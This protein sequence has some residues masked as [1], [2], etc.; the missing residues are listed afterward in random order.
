M[1]VPRNTKCNPYAAHFPYNLSNPGN[2][3]TS[4]KQYSTKSRLTLLCPSINSA[5]MCRVFA[6]TA[7]SSTRL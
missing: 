5:G 4:G 1:T 3:P 7:A 6:A 2:L